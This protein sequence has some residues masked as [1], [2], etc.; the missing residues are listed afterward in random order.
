MKGNKIK[1]I[2][3]S[4]KPASSLCPNFGE[5]SKNASQRMYRE[6]LGL[7]FNQESLVPTQEFAKTSVSAS[8]SGENE[9]NTFF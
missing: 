4:D 7:Q 9:D 6:V 3:Q 8:G 2:F 1:S 5:M